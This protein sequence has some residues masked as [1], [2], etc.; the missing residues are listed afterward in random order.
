MP[1]HRAGATSDD[2]L[3]AI[4]D[5]DDDDDFR[6]SLESLLASLGFAV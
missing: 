2:P 6:E 1:P 5:D 3:I 4:V